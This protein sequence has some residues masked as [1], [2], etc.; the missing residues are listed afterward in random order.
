MDVKKFGS[1]PRKRISGLKKCLG[2]DCKCLVCLGQVLVQEKTLKKLIELHTRLNPTASDWK[3][4]AGLRSRIVDLT[5]ELH[6]GQPFEKMKALHNLVR[7]AHLARD[8]DLL[9]KA[10]DKWRQLA[11]ETKLEVFQRK[12][13]NREMDKEIR[14]ELTHDALLVQAQSRVDARGP[15]FDPL[16]H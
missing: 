2:F 3:R 15:V 12:Y 6:I 14:G 10:M 1:I 7:F 16:N 9:K 8:K 11:E 5:M 4:E 13:K